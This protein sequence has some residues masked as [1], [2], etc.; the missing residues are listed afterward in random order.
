[1]KKHAKRKIKRHIHPEN[2]YTHTYTH[3]ARKRETKEYV[4]QKSYLK[5]K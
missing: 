3:E 5:K 4:E 2:I 1:M